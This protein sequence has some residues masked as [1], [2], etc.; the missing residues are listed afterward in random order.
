MASTFMTGQLP[1]PVMFQLPRDAKVGEPQVRL[2]HTEDSVTSP[3]Q[4]TQ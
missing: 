2:L 3:T 1:Q 4:R